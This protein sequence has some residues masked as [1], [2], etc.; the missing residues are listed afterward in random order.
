M[1][2]GIRGPFATA[3]AVP[4]SE[5]SAFVP[6]TGNL[7]LQINLLEDVF[8]HRDILDPKR[9]ASYTVW[10]T[11]VVHPWVMSDPNLQAV[12]RHIYRTN[13]LMDKDFVD[14]LKKL[15]PIT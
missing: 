7:F 12:M 8:Q 9:V 5:L 4:E 2:Y 6:K 10:A 13:D 1:R 14:W 15:I 11:E 3:L